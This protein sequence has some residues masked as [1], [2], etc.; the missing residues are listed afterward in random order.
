MFV[1]AQ[2]GALINLSLVTEIRIIEAAK[3]MVTATFVGEPVYTVIAEC[4]TR[5]EAKSVLA[6]IQDALAARN[7]CRVLMTIPDKKE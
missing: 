1:V 6:E 7:E 5:E 3:W 4:D 2:N